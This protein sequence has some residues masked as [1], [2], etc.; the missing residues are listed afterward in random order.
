MYNL[1][2]DTQSVQRKTGKKNKVNGRCEQN[3]PE[4]KTTGYKRKIRSTGGSFDKS[5]DYV[6]KEQF[7]LLS[8]DDKL[9]VLYDM[10]I[11]KNQIKQSKKC[12]TKCCLPTKT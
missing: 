9:N 10:V 3:N 4:W 1:E 2:K 7:I 12:P 6:S 11:H 8:S 5:L